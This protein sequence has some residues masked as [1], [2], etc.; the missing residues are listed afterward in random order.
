MTRRMMAAHG[1]RHQEAERT[2]RTMRAVLAWDNEVF[3]RFD[4]D[5]AV[6]N[7]SGAVARPPET[8]PSRRGF[9]PLWATWLLITQ[10]GS[11]TSRPNTCPASSTPSRTRGIPR[12][13]GPGRATASHPAAS[14]P[15]G[16]TGEGREFT[17]RWMVR[18]HWRN[19]P[20]GPGRSR[21]RPTSINP[22]VKGP[23]GAP[24]R[25]GEKVYLIDPP[26]TH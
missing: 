9:R 1:M 10:P 24:L 25:T 19:Q 8:R 26:H 15:V 2:V 12:R 14:G 4:D 13:T 22:H 17:V 18:G 20:Y 11:P 3:L 5:T 23:D 6:V 21:R 7:P 16:A